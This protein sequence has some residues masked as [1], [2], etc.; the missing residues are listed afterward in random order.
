MDLTN[1]T[2]IAWLALLDFLDEAVS[3]HTKD[4]RVLYINARLLEMLGGK[5]ETWLGRSCD[6]LFPPG[7]C[8]HEEALKSEA[9]VRIRSAVDG[10]TVIIVPLQ[11][12]AS[13]AAAF[14]RVVSR[15]EALSQDALLK[16][17]HLATLGQM[18]SG[19]AHDVGTPLNIISGYAEYLLM[20]T[21]P[22]ETG[23]KELMA[24]LEQTR[25]V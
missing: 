17:E 24:I 9:P 6:E 18:M 8:P 2:A 23:H 25:R 3:I 10:R 11:G 13:E 16:A 15:Q 14:A 4:G 5:A 12:E 21:K 7:D 20:R 19:I 22:E 1:Q